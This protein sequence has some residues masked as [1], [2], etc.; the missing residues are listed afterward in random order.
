MRLRFTIRDLFGLTLVAALAVGFW[1]RLP[2]AYAIGWLMVLLIVITIIF[3]L[4][5]WPH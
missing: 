4:F 5:S 3:V 1:L 2:M